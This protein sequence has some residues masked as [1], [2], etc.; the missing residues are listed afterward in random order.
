MQEQQEQQPKPTPHKHADLI[1]EWALDTS[2][3]VQYRYTS[4][5]EW[6][7]CKD[8]PAWDKAIQYRF[9]PEPKP[10][11]HTYAVILNN[12]LQVSFAGKPNI[13]FT[14]C[15]ETHQLKAAGVLK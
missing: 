2:R 9:K 12:S 10:D 3:V 15:G 7:D 4:T 8:Y 14:F 5:N 13:K 1:R 6:E 11:Y